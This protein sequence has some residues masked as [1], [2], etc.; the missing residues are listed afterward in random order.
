VVEP[1]DANPPLPLHVAV[2]RAT[3]Q[4]SRD[5]RV[6]MV[7]VPSRSGATARMMAAARPA[8]PIVAVS[9]D[10][11]VCRRL[12]LLWGVV[13]HV[14]E[15]ADLAQLPELARRVARDLGL[16]ARG[17][18]LL[19]VYGFGADGSEVAPVITALPA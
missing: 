16:A 11:G 12:S 10:A 14:A 19:L 2:A 5:L 4:L 13:P 18:F 17:E 8:A 7:V 6:R 9:S 15:A 1:P 3:G